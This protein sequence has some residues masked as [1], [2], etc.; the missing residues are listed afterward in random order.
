MRLKIP[1]LFALVVAKGYFIWLKLPASQWQLFNNQ[2][3]E[4]IRSEQC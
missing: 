2:Q 1:Q 3:K 4:P